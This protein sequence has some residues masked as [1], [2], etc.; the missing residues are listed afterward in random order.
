MS[1][2]QKGG[3]IQCHY[4]Y[5]FDAPNNLASICITFQNGLKIKQI[6]KKLI[7]F[8]LFLHIDFFCAFRVMDSYSLTFLIDSIYKV[9]IFSFL[10]PS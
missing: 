4:L 5:L 1:P 8:V 3:V 6:R 7:V 10:L 9:G 2:K